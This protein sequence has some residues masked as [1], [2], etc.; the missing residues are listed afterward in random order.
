[1][2]TPFLPVFSCTLSVQL[3]HPLTGQSYTL[4]RADELPLT[5]QR[6]V[7]V[8]AVCNEPLVYDRLFR[9]R[10]QGRPYAVGEGEDFLT[11]AAAGWRNGTHFVF[12]LLDPEQRVA[13]A[14]D[15]K[16]PERE[17]GEVG[18]WLGGAHRGIMTSALL[19][20]LDAAREA[21]FVRLWARPDA[22]NARSLALL[23]RA[24]F[25]TFAPAEVAANTAYLERHL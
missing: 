5:H 10:R 16:S 21:G 18:Y 4:L 19:A 1:M 23:E 6:A 24:G 11:W 8:A 13:G 17:A 12:L 14:L 9:A 22:D 15:V 7:E 20:M 25:G 3:S 2:T